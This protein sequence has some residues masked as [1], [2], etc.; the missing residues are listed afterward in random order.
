MT[1]IVANNPHIFLLSV[2]NVL[3]ISSI[4]QHPVLS[5]YIN[6]N[7]QHFKT[8]NAMYQYYLVK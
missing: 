4:L 6:T 5:V 8:C 7:Y 3:Q 2:T 1:I